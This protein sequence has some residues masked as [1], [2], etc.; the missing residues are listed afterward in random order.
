MESS[1]LHFLLKLWMIEVLLNGS[2]QY[3]ISMSVFNGYEACIY[4]NVFMLVQQWQE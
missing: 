4:W 2:A 1:I 3:K